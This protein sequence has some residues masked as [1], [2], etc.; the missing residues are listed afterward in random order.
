MT[1]KGYDHLKLR[2]VWTTSTPQ[3]LAQLRH[4]ADFGEWCLQEVAADLSSTWLEE[5]NR[6]SAEVNVLR[7]LGYPFNFPGPYLLWPVSDRATGVARSE[8]GHSSPRLL[9]TY[10]TD[11]ILIISIRARGT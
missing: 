4:A 7:T 10:C 11:E 8:T 3:A 5:N 6:S 2:E 1:N 9:R